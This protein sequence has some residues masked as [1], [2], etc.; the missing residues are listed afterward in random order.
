MAR[1][2]TLDRKALR[3][4]AEAAE[5]QEHVEGETEDEEEGDEEEAEPDA[6]EAAGDED[7]EE[8]VVVKPKKKK[9]PA[10][11]RTRT[12][13]VVRMRVVWGVFDNSSKRVETF[14]YKDKHLA[15]AFIAEKGP[16]KKLY[17]QPVKEPMEEK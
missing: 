10:R 7:D 16:E 6:E 1:R 5:R 13:K 4:N 12:A 9:A 11:P 2:R 15:E 3:E 17:L 14:P 8:V